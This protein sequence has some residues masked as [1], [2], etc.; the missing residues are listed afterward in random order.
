MVE[1]LTDVAAVVLFAAIAT[2][3]VG[4]VGAMLWLIFVGVKCIYQ[5]FFGDGNPVCGNFSIN[6]NF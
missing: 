1:L 5:Y 3:E 4:Y 6:F 2:L